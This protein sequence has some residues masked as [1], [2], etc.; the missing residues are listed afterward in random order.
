MS[1]FH[2]KGSEIEGQYYCPDCERWLDEVDI[3][4]VDEPRGEYWGVPCTEHMVYRYCP[5]CGSED[6]IDAEDIIL[7]NE[8]EEE[9]E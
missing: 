9:D 5:I 2:V 3:E 4:E 7:D 1:Y 8:E 6:I